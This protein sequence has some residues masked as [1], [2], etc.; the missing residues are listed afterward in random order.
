MFNCWCINHLGILK[1]HVYVN[2][3]H[4][5]LTV[6]G[7]VH[8]TWNEINAS[9]LKL[10]CCFGPQTAVDK[11]LKH[12]QNV[13]IDLPSSDWLIISRDKLL[14]GGRTYSHRNHGTMIL[15]MSMSQQEDKSRSNNPTIWYMF[16]KN[17]NNIDSLNHS[18]YPP[19]LKMLTGLFV[20]RK[21]KWISPLE[22]NTLLYKV[23]LSKSSNFHDN[24]MDAD[25]PEEPRDK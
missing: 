1:K 3:S 25:Y 21:D 16:Q 12:P 14:F 24:S 13:V 23:P 15:A 22:I 9:I 10:V 6:K 11:V 8:L 17:P 7:I 4:W 5:N 19:W 2:Y 18:V 20:K